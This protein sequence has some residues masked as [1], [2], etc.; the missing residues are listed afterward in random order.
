MPDRHKDGSHVVTVRFS[1]EEWERLQ[2]I[3]GRS[4]L[5]HDTPAGFI[6]WLFQ[7]QVMRPR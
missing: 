4:P 6:R 5:T 2:L 3:I 1:A 7:T